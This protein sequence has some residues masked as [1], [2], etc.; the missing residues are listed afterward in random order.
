MDAFSEIQ[1][2][3][4][5]IKLVPPRDQWREVAPF[6]SIPEG[7][8]AV[9]SG[10]ICMAER[11]SKLDLEALFMRLSDNIGVGFQADVLDSRPDIS[12]RSKDVITRQEEIGFITLVSSFARFSLSNTGV[13][14]GDKISPCRTAPSPYAYVIWPETA[15]IT[16]DDGN[17]GAK[18]GLASWCETYNL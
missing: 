8:E 18:L 7:D 12:F 9:I 15:R 13:L 3:L 16:F 2:S 6:P 4:Q 11:I 10:E 17:L 1:R 5:T 14:G